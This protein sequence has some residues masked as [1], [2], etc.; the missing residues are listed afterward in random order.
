MTA[1]QTTFAINTESTYDWETR[2]W[3]IPINMTVAQLLRVG[4]QMVQ[5]GGGVR[6]WVTAPDGGPEGW[7]LRLQF[8]LL[9]PR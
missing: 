9:Y 4:N 5:I 2:D 1:S 8:T 3:A 7:G 6:Y